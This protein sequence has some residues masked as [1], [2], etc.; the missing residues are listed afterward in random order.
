MAG[1]TKEQRAQRDAEKLASGNEQQN[2]GETPETPSE[3]VA[4]HCEF[5]AFP[6]APTEADVHPD[7]VKNWIDAGWKVKG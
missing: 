2:T 7:E 6:G 3:L 4:M 1:L 5:E